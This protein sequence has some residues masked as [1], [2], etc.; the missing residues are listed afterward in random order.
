M[1]KTLRTVIVDDEL[2]AINSLLLALDNH[3]DICVAGIAENYADA[4]TVLIE[5]KPDVLFLD[6]EMHGKSGIELL[7][8]IRGNEFPF[9]VIFYSA[10]HKYALNAIQ[11]SSFDYI[12][13]PVNPLDL[14]KSLNRL[15]QK[16]LKSIINPAFT[17]SPFNLEIISLPTATGIRFSRVSDIVFIK[18]E[19]EQGWSKSYWYAVLVTGEKIRLKAGL[20]SIQIKDALINLNFLQINQSVIINLIYIKNVEIKTRHCFLLPPLE[21]FHFC[22]SRNCMLQIRDMFDGFSVFKGIK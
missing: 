8:D 16:N 5:A 15:R 18:H 3:D 13:K 9:H 21:E 22:I 11:G 19:R 10:N 14:N 4:R 17:H 1:K 7:K 2:S 12:L 20:N 6:T